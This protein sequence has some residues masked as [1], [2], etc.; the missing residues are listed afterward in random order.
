M[1]LPLQGVKVIELGTLIAGPFCARLLA[2]FGAEVIK[3]EPPGGGDPLRKWRKLLDG[4]SLWWMTAA[5]KTLSGDCLLQL[6]E[7]ERV[8]SPEP[9]PAWR[10]ANSPLLRQQHPSCTGYK[11]TGTLGTLRPCQ[12]FQL[13]SLSAATTS[14]A[15][16]SNTYR[17]LDTVEVS[18]TYVPQSRETLRTTD[19]L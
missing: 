7:E 9:I 3:I 5:I 1:P 19:G 4:T 11:I 17:A 13:Q 14:G 16:L 12:A 18:V 2:E 8:G 6:A 10:D 15:A